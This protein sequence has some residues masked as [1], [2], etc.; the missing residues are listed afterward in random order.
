MLYITK[1]FD[2][3]ELIKEDKGTLKIAAAGEP[4]T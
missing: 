4:T 1:P 3:T 2:F